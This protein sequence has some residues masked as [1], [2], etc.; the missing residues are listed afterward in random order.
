MSSTMIIDENEF[1]DNQEEEVPQ[2]QD[3][4]KPHPGTIIAIVT[5]VLLLTEKDK[6][7]NE[8]E[9]LYL[10]I[11]QHLLSFNGVRKAKIDLSSSLFAYYLEA[12]RALQ[13]CKRVAEDKTLS[14]QDPK[15]LSLYN[16]AALSLFDLYL[17]CP[18]DGLIRRLLPL[19]AQALNDVVTVYQ[20]SD[21]DISAKEVLNTLSTIALL[22]QTVR[23]YTKGIKRRKNYPYI[24]WL[25]SFFE[26]AV[27]TK[28]LSFMKE[29]DLFKHVISQITNNESVIHI[30]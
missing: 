3:L 18:N 27:S 26:K 1:I 9:V 14:P 13:F 12:Y 17:I 20:S 28:D 25:K 15:I 16:D 7:A 21:E 23:S 4:L 30:S 29:D 19:S 22:T 24:K 8:L 5:T 11:K 10:T 2:T 6:K